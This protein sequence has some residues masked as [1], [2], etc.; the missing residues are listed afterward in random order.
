MN[1]RASSTFA[2]AMLAFFIL[3]GCA[4][5]QKIDWPSRVGNYT[6]DQAV[7]EYGRPVGSARSADGGTIADWLIQRGHGRPAPAARF[8]ARG[9]VAGSLM[10]TM[11]EPYVPDYYMRLV[12]GPD[13]RLKEHKEFAR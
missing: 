8:G 2:A 6:Y 10:P 4:T 1:T 7:A 5:T 13:A 11:A 12:F 9:G 3:V